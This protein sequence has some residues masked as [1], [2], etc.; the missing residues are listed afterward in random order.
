LPGVS[1]DGLRRHLT[2]RFGEVVRGQDLTGALIE[3]MWDLWK[4]EFE[5]LGDERDRF[6]HFVETCEGLTSVGLFRR[7]TGA[8]IGFWS[9]ETHHRHWRGVD[10][11]QVYVPHYVLRS[12]MRGSVAPYATAIRGFAG[13]FARHPRS[14]IY[15]VA[16]SFP[17]SYI[18]IRSGPTRVATLANADPWEESLLLDVAATMGGEAWD[19]QMGLIR[20]HQIPRD[21][22]RPVQPHGK[23]AQ[24]FDEYMRLNPTWRQGTVI[25]I[26][27]RV[28]VNPRAWVRQVTGRHLR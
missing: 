15:V 9:A 26:L 16:G 7:P 28:Q 25:P 12:S 3:Q 19:P 20:G 21:A 10:F 5:L 6:Q 4:R 8:L 24:F 18:A 14:P 17:G 22:D 13:D 2:S 11:T 1:A 27:V 23:H